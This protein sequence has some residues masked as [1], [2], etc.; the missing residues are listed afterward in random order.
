[1]DQAPTMIDATFKN[2]I[3]PICN[4][5]PRGFASYE[6]FARL[7][8]ATGVSKIL[9]GGSLDDKR[10]QAMSHLKSGLAGSNETTLVNL[11]TLSDMKCLL[12]ENAGPMNRE[13]KAVFQRILALVNE[14]HI[15]ASCNLE[16]TDHSIWRDAASAI[17]DGDS[18]PDNIRIVFSKAQS[19]AHQRWNSADN[20]LTNLVQEAHEL[21][22]T[23]GL[24][25]TVGRDTRGFKADIEAVMSGVSAFTLDLEGQP[26][27][28]V[29]HAVAGM[30]LGATEITCSP[31]RS[32]K[33]RAVHTL[34][35][36]AELDQALD[37]QL[38]GSDEPLAEI[39]R[40]FHG[41]Y[42]QILDPQKAHRPIRPPHPAASA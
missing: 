34:D 10:L 40:M 41:D 31:L 15:H 28:I 8:A 30:V 39:R 29:Q 5:E 26:E 25:T 13:D 32:S 21:G 3:L 19:D 18:S 2:G 27:Q 11:M 14:V 9:V 20:R 23:V 38:T 4:H 22:Y 16:G 6:T 42:R 12:L 24:Q 7:V 35:L 33:S 17:R 1:M 36:R 37:I